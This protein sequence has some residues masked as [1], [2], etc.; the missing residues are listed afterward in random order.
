MTAAAPIESPAPVRGRCTKMGGPR[1]G[2]CVER[3][4]VHQCLYIPEPL[5]QVFHSATEP[6]VIME[7]SR[8]GGKSHAMRW[9]AYMRCLSTPGFKAVIIRRVMPELKKS[10]LMFVPREVEMLGG[11]GVARYN[12]SEHTITF[13]NH[14]I[15]MF[16]HA[17]DDRA[18]EKYLSSEWDA[19]YFDEIVTYTLREFLLISASAR[20]RADSGRNAIV[21]GGTNPIGRG[22][23]WVKAYFLDHNPSYEEAPDYDPAEWRAIHVDMDDNSHVNIADYEKRMR[24]LPSEALRRAYRHGEWVSEGAMFSEWRET[25]NGR[26]WHVIEELPK[27][28]GTP[29]PE[30]PWVE[31]V[32]AVDWGYSAEGNP[33]V[34]LWAAMLPDHTCVVFQEYYFKQTLPTDVAAEI[35]RRSA[36]MKVRYT[37]AD[38]AMF[39]E[40]TGESIAETFNR[41]G[42][43]LMD[44]DNERKSGWVRL[45]AWLRETVNDGT[46]E[47]PRLQVYRGASGAGCP[48]LARSIPTLIVDPKDPEDLET[49]GVEDDGADALRYLVMSRLTPSREPQI[50]SGI[51]AMLTAIAKRRRSEGRLGV[52]AMRR[53]A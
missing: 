38:P 1:D 37:V 36:G 19:I 27:V 34:C 46:G 14:S 4:G 44:G 6:N 22:A 29:L 5:Q 2:F 18:V 45:H 3:D 47:R 51:Q 17:E 28:K 12:R 35:K 20:T 11:E 50:D 25:F 30:V 15:I 43:P 7:G 53:P 31:I 52:E 48:T 32:R 10:H 23:K 39:R 9:D 8:G 49:R 16:G 26:P 33:G 21:R 42:V 40:H 24:N 41:H 13:Y